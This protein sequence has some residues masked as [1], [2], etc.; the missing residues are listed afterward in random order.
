MARVAVL[1]AALLASGCAW[2]AAGT[3]HYFGPVLFRYRE[4]PDHGT[5]VSEVIRLAVAGEAGRQWGI[6]VGM[7]RRLMAAAQD[8]CI[9]KE[10][11]I[12]PR[13][14]VALSPYGTPHPGRWTFSPVYLRVDHLAETRFVSRTLYGA[15][16]T[17]GHETS[18]LSLGVVSR[19]LFEVP[20]DSFVRLRFDTDR[21][22]E[23]TLRLCRDLPGRPLP[24]TILEEIER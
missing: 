10:E 23:T 6:S 15:E 17:A 18:A 16:V 22:M 8:S 4:T 3:E 19:S 21:P 13:L 20:G 11:P 7:S 1:S 24:L 12:S 14:R 5:L 9:E 2:H